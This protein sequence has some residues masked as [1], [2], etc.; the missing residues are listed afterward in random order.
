[1]EKLQM[2]F[3]KLLKNILKIA[4]ITIIDNLY[5]AVINFAGFSMN[6][7]MI[8]VNKTE[9]CFIEIETDEMIFSLPAPKQKQ[10]IIDLCKETWNG[11]IL[12]IETKIM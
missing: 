5:K 1:M 6:D 3:D 9:I 2:N 10:F 12:T 7:I 11:S 8:V 4:R